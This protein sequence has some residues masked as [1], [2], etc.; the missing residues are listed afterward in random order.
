MTIHHRTTTVD[1]IDLFYREAGDP[2]N[3]T[4]LLLHGFPSSSF[5]F[6]ELMPTLS[7]RLHLVAPDYPG[8]GSTVAPP[9]S[10]FTYSFDTL[11]G[12]LEAFVDELE[13]ARFGIYIQDY[14]APVGTRLA[15]RRPEAIEAIVVQNGNAY[16][17]GF[18]AA[19]K[20]LREGLWLGRTPEREAA[21]IAGFISREGIEANWSAGARDPV[22]LS[23]DGPNMDTYFM[24][25]PHRTEIQLELL[26]DYR[27]NPAHYPAFHAY[28]RGYMPPMLTAWGKH[29]PYFTVEGARAYLRDQPDAQLHLL[30]TGHFALEEECAAIAALIAD[31]YDSEVA[32]TPAPVTTP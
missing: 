6:R 30:P 12:V 16:D 4:L 8:F 23:P 32:A 31:F 20:P 17:E 10:E 28:L 9:P 24:S 25:L 11:A 19:W 22:A 5:M 7:D 13:L 18:S 2:A 14:G 21:A 15:T 29:D 26:Y 1:G 3:P 27:H